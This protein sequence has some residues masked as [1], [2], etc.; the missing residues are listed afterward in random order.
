MTVTTLGLNVF[1]NAIVS[2]IAGGAVIKN[3]VTETVNIYKSEVVGSE[4]RVY[5]LFD[6]IYAG[7]LTQFQL[8]DA[9]NQILV[10][11]ADSIAKVANKLLLVTFK[12]NLSERVTV[13]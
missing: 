7:T 4:L 8:R 9:S 11:Q 13:S 10:S 12:F 2:K 1:A 3:G 6:Q 5:L